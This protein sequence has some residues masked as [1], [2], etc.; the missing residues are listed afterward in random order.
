MVS[1]ESLHI[2]FL[3]QKAMDMVQWTS[4]FDQM[5]LVMHS[6]DALPYYAAMAHKRNC[7]KIACELLAH[8]CWRV[9]CE[10]G[11]CALQAEPGLTN[12]I[13]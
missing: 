13:P 6:V 10:T 2:H 12:P 4:A 11:A 1:S 8:F 3:L 9:C 7:L 5:A